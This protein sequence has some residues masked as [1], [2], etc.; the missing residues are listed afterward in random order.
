[1]KKIPTGA[2]ASNVMVGEADFLDRPLIVFIRLQQGLLLGMLHVYR[3]VFKAL[4]TFPP[5]RKVLIN[6]VSTFGVFF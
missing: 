6:Q 2:E 4:F 1:M 3:Y 5:M